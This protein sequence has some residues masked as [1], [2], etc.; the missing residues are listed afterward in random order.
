MNRQDVEARTEELFRGGLHC[1]EAVLQA[2]LES[3]GVG[4]AE[5]SPRMA[6]A[7]GGGVGRSKKGLCGALSGGLMA[8][9]YLRGRSGPQESWDEVA[10]TAEALRQGFATEY[11]CTRCFVVLEKL[12]TQERM[13]K[14]IRLA[15]RTAGM[16]HEA[17][18]ED[19]ASRPVQACGCGELHA[20]PAATAPGGCGC[21]CGCK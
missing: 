12:G 19:S 3:Q 1:A 11:G 10:A 6:T 8:L 16:V 20:A 4:E 14:C 2:V 13:D 5:F 17:L 21:G 7:F 9:G 15:G 18:G